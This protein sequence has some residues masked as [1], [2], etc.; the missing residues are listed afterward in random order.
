MA[1]NNQALFLFLI[2]LAGLVLCSFL[3]GNCM[4]EGFDPTPT[5]TGVNSGTTSGKSTSNPNLGGQGNVYMG[6]TNN[7]QRAAYDNYNH[8]SGTAAQMNNPNSV[9]ANK[10]NDVI[11]QGTPSN[12]PYSSSMPK[13]IPANQILPGQEDLYILKSKIVPP[14][15]PICPSASLCE[16]K[17]KCPPCPAC[18][19]CPEPSFEC[20]KVPNYNSPS[21]DF[22]PV[23]VLNRFSTFGM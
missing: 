18:A 22:L 13:G 21:G 5:Y 12:N 7:P 11:S 17:E 20:K 15:C 1:I 23:P 9:Y 14:V 19:R 6:T 16:R 10:R 2:L 4:T 3:G 8:Y